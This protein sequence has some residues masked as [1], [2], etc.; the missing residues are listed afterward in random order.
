MIPLIDSYILLRICFC[1]EDGLSG[2]EGADAVGGRGSGKAGSAGDGRD[3]LVDL[4]QKA[5]TDESFLDA[6]VRTGQTEP[7]R[8]IY[9]DPELGFCICA[10]VYGDAAHSAPHDHGTSWAIYGQ[11]E[12]ETEMT[13]WRIVRAATGDAPALVEPDRTYTMTPGMAHYYAPGAVHSPKRDGATK[14]L[15]IEGANLDLVERTPIKRADTAA[16]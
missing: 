14:L 5:L 6:N 4:V 3:K 15:R 16:A 10:H 8:V 7:R 1:E 13:D 12:G 11:A 2:F 9:E